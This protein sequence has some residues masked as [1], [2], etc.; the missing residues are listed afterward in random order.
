[1]SQR[2][3]INSRYFGV[4]SSL[5]W[6]SYSVE[7][8]DDEDGDDGGDG[9]AIWEGRCS[10][11][12]EEDVDEGADEGTE[13]DEREGLKVGALP[14]PNDVWRPSERLCGCPTSPDIETGM[15]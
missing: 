3:L 7:V 15:R 8:E 2:W 10:D 12:V 6:A 1:V 4:L 14:R 5:L 11:D 9:A 13:D